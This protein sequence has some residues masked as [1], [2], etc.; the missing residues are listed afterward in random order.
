M[1]LAFDTSK[2]ITNEW[3]SMKNYSKVVLKQLYKIITL[4]L[5]TDILEEPENTQNTH[6]FQIGDYKLLSLI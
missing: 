2:V 6:K 4:P 5:L 3:F 1:N